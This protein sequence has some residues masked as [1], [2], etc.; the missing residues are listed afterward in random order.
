MNQEHGC[1]ASA[2]LEKQPTADSR[3]VGQC[4]IPHADKETRSILSAAKGKETRTKL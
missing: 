1:S 2:G 3:A 4:F